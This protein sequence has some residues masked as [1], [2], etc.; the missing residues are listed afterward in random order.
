VTLYRL[1][2]GSKELDLST[3]SAKCCEIVLSPVSPAS[4]VVQ[5]IRTW[6]YA[7]LATMNWLR[8]KQQDTQAIQVVLEVASWRAVSPLSQGEYV[9]GR[10]PGAPEGSQQA[11]TGEH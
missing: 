5:G 10:S 2:I 7:I 9:T 4:G 3:G 11:K 8:T 6:P 1:N